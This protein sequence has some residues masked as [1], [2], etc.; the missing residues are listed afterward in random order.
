MPEIIDED[1]H[2]L[3]L[4]SK[5]RN[6]PLLKRPYVGRGKIS[7]YSLPKSNKHV[8]GKPN[9]PKDVPA[10]M[11]INGWK[12]HNPTETKEG[13]K[14]RKN[15]VNI[16]RMALKRGKITAKEVNDFR[17]NTSIN[18]NRQRKEIKSPTKKALEE[19]KKTD[20]SRVYGKP[21][22]VNGDDTDMKWVMSMT[23][24]SKWV[25]S[26]ETLFQQKFNPHNHKNGKYAQ[27][28]P[29]KASIGHSA[30]YKSQQNTINQKKQK[31]LEMQKYKKV[32][33]DYIKP[34]VTLPDNRKKSQTPKFSNRN[35]HNVNLPG[36]PFS[37]I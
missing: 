30:Y 25:K 36:R 20:R 35:N 31:E 37:A 3:P 1:N 2:Y 7:S 5:F 9:P 34:K 24:Y 8:Y 16:N 27:V 29:T 32:K 15:F 22:N 26:Q 11:V 4:K 28:K 23:Y 19:M 14:H 21:S 33:Y 13:S 6:N 18:T 12:Y 10:S 17:K